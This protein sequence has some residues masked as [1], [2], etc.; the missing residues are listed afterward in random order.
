MQ[1]VTGG[2]AGGPH[3]TKYGP[4]GHLGAHLVKGRFI[5]M[6]IHGGHSVGMLYLD[7]IA[8][9]FVVTG[10][11]HRTVGGTVNFSSA[12]SRNI[13]TSVEALLFSGNRMCPGSEVRRNSGSSRQGPLQE[14]GGNSSR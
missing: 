1:V 7:H 3:V 13:H 12:G 5:H 8:V 6:G 10:F 4:L 9:G 14:T 11:G 2:P